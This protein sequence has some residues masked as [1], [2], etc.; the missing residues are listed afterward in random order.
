[1]IASGD[2]DQ[3]TITLMGDKVLGHSWEPTGDKFTF[4]ITVNLT[5]AKMKRRL[6]ETSKELSV[7]D[8]PRLPGMQLT[9]RVLLGFVNSQYDPMGFLFYFCK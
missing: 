3:E 5:P 1:M 2:T 7:E 8:I 6:Q 9:K 4:R